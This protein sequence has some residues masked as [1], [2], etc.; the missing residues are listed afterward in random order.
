MPLKELAV[1]EILSGQ[2]GIFDRHVRSGGLA[3]DS[4]PW[5]DEKKGPS[6]LR[7]SGLATLAG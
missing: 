2:A 7:S 6:S 1:G 5:S 3:Q 4:H